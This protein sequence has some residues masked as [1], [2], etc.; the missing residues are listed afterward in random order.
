M[1]RYRD[2]EPRTGGDTSIETQ[3]ARNTDTETE[4]GSQAGKQAETVAAAQPVTERDRQICRDRHR[5]TNRAN[6]G[7]QTQTQNKDKDIP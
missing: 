4:K 7:R 3:P 1:E 2:K 6:R 5:Q